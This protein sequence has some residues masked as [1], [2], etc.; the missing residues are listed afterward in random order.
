MKKLISLTLA[1]A[2]AISLAACGGEA[3]STKSDAV[4]LVTVLTA[5][6]IGV[7]LPSDMTLQ[8]NGGYAN[9][10]T[11]DIA[12]FALY[13]EAPQSPFSEWTQEDFVDAEL[14]T[15]SDVVVT[16]YENDLQINGNSALV[17]LYT[18]KTSGGIAT[19]SSVI[20]IT[21][22]TNEAVATFQHLTENADGSLATNLQAC[23][24]SIVIPAA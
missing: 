5:D 2:M 8:A 9:T 15:Y 19:T 22:G 14:S 18:Y 4:S 23:I 16:S 11:S 10:K 12:I 13:N 7:K 3:T 24:D 21:D 20:L 1:L 17:C 6:N